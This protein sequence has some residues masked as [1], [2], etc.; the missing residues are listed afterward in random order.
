MSDFLKDKLCKAHL[1][2]QD[3]K[4]NCILVGKTLCI[5]CK[6]IRDAR[7]YARYKKT[8]K[9]KARI[10]RHRY[11]EKNTEHTE[12]YFAAIEKLSR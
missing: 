3:Y 9:Y 11:S 8:D 2:T 1:E 10:K 7:A 5:R 4:D 12:K 6:K